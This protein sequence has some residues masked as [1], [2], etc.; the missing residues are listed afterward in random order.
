[1][2][3]LF[4][5]SVWAFSRPGAC[6]SGR[7]PVLVSPWRARS[8][9]V[10]GGQLL[11]FRLQLVGAPPWVLPLAA[12][13]CASLVKRVRVR[14][15]LAGGRRFAPSRRVCAVRVSLP[16]ARQRVPASGRAVS[17]REAIPRYAAQLDADLSV[18]D[19]T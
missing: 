14:L 7:A 3:I 4:I 17:L 6:L 16:C 18:A 1:M 9:G 19:L 11:S 10:A 13:R 5:F 15:P 2:K 8:V 12:A